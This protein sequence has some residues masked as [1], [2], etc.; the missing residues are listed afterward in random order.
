[1]NNF[2]PTRITII[3]FISKNIQRKIKNLIKINIITKS[4]FHRKIKFNFLKLFN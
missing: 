4:D 1:M 2:I 3:K